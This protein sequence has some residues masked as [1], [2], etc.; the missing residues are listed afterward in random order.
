[1]MNT[2]RYR[3]QNRCMFSCLLKKPSTTIISTITNSE[4]NVATNR[5]HIGNS[6]ESSAIKGKTT[7]VTRIIDTQ[8][9]R[10]IGQG[11]SVLS[12]F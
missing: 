4:Y 1:M 11:G 8:F 5:L 3:K 7:F 2:P 9:G 10:Y 12:N 6:T